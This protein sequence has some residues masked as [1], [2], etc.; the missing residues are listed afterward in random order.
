MLPFIPLA[1]FLVS[2]A[3]ALEPIKSGEMNG[4]EKRQNAEYCGMDGK[5][6]LLCFEITSYPSLG[7][8]SS[9]I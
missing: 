4:L 6:T 7:M 3:V 2:H 1:V 9:S 5:S 8:T